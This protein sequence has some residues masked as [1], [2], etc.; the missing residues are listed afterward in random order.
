MTDRSAIV[1]WL[2]QSDPSIRW[3]V[4]RDLTDEPEEVVA[5]ERSRVA[6]EGWGAELLALQSPDGHWSDEQEH[7]WMSTNDALALLKEL[8]ADPADEKVRS[9]VDLVQERIAWWQLDGRPFFDG[10]T[11]ACIN[12][13]ILAAGAYFGAPVERLL[14][15]LLDEQLADGGWNCEAPPSTRSSFHSTICVLE[16]LLAYEEAHGATPA[17][18]QARARGQDY[19]LERRMLRSLTTGEVIKARW[20]Q[21]SF[22][23]IWYYDVLRGLD[24]LRSADVKPDE[25]VGEAVALVEQRRDANGRWAL[26]VLNPDHERIP[27]DMETNIGH[28]SRWNTLRALR[29]LDWHAG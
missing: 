5:A 7:G 24:Y 16:G 20:T 25:R 8:G 2:L 10:E 15:R 29:V 23:T 4:L 18:T 1:E 9:A 12:G 13:R 11:E 17:V 27:L 22:P 26:D 28:A 3:Q 19:L 14:G 6:W 21:F